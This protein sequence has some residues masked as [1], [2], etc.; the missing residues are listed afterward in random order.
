MNP[1][2]FGEHIICLVLGVQ[3]PVN[4]RKEDGLV[5]KYR[6]SN[7][8]TIDKDAKSVAYPSQASLKWTTVGTEEDGLLNIGKYC[9]KQRSDSFPLYSNDLVWLKLDLDSDK[10]IQRKL[11]FDF[12]NRVWV[13]LN[14]NILYHGDHSWPFYQGIIQKK[15]IG[16]ALFLPLR[17][18]K[19]ELLIGV[20]SVTNGWGIISK[21]E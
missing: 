14:G 7:A 11:S 6:L 17:K 1:S 10:E 3:L 21:I 9:A 5:T 8:F 20:S 16:D 4:S 18:G 13:F 2:F 12:S 15:F 19:N